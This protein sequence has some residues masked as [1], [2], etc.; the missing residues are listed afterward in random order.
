MAQNIDDIGY[1]LLSQ[2]GLLGTCWLGRAGL[3]RW[4]DVLVHHSS[5][6][7]VTP[8]LAQHAVCHPLQPPESPVVYTPHRECDGGSRI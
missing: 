2:R 3:L 7:W 1:R 8:L 5:C 6:R 4:I